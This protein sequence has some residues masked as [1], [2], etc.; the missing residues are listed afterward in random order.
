M[1]VGSKGIQRI[2]LK[3]FTMKGKKLIVT[4]H[5]FYFSNGC[6]VK[7]MPVV[8]DGKAHGLFNVTISFPLTDGSDTVFTQRQG[9]PTAHASLHRLKWAIKD[10][11]NKE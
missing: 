3:L 8:N 1:F 10:R 7:W 6:S 5:S 9:P 11:E 4:L 2:T